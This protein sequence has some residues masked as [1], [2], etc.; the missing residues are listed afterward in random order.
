MLSFRHG[1]CPH[2][3]IIAV[4]WYFSLAKGVYWTLVQ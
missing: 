4:G 3:L 1:L 2:R